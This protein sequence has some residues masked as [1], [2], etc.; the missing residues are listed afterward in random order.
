M[1]YNE[2][3][4]E[5]T[6]L[7]IAKPQSPGLVDTLSAGY[8]ALHRRPWALLIPAGVS[9]YLWLGKPV[10]IDGMFNGLR[11]SIRQA[12]QL[13]GG[14]QQAQQEMVA[15]FMGSDIQLSLAWLNLVPVLAPSRRVS[16]AQSVL[17][18]SSP[19]QLMGAFTVINLLSLLISS[20]FLTVLGG[21][22]CSERFALTP[23]IQR[24]LQVAGDIGKALLIALGV[25]LLISLPFLAISAIIIAYIPSTALPI[26]LAWY[27]A[28]FWA[29]I[30]I[31]FTPEAL[32]MSQSGSLHA[33][34]QS[35]NVVR[36]NLIRTVGLLVM[37]VL[38]I[39]GFGII[40]QRI[41]TS[42]FGL[43]VAILGSAYV[44]SGLSAARLEFYRSQA[45]HLR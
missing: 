14:N 3:V 4:V 29:Y 18:L 24:S 45:A 43:T 41:I 5:E 26:V 40:W 20:L 36:H 12:A 16:Q 1:W 6:V 10:I 22:V 32:L 39:S 33:L 38:I 25:G 15:R 34:Y 2:E 42:P 44:G 27:I 7:S 28:C 9:T 19:I 35:I 31:G 17:A 8:R 13:L 21:A 23:T 30:Y 37:S 11:E